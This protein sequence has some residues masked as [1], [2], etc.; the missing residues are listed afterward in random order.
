MPADASI[1]LIKAVAWLMFALAITA[2]RNAVLMVE[3]LE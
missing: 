1:E 3:A 2:V